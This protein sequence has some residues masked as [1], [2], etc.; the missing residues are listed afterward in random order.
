VL[1]VFSTIQII[2][3]EV[4]TKKGEKK[5]ETLKGSDSPQAT[6]DKIEFN[7][8]AGNPILTITDEGG[9]AGSITLP[10]STPSNTSNKLYNEG[11]II[12]FNGVAIGGNGATEIDDLSDAIYNGNSIFIGELAG[13]NDDGST[14]VGN[15]AFGKQALYNNINGGGNT[16]IGLFSLSNILG[17][18]NTAIGRFSM[19]GS[20][21]IKDASNNT[22]VGSAALRF[23]DSGSENVAIGNSSL[24]SN[25][26]GNKNTVVGTNGLA[27]GTT[28]SNN[29]SIGYS[30]DAYGEGSNNTIIGYEAGY[31]NNPNSKSGSVF[32]GYQAGYFE[33]TDNKLYI[34]NS[35]SATPLIW[36]DFVN[37]DVKINGDFHVTGNITTDG[38]IP[39]VSEINDLSDART[40]GNSIFLGS[41]SG[42]SDDGSDNKN[43]GFGINTLGSNTTGYA[44]TAMGYNSLFFNTEGIQ[45]VGLGQGSLYSNT[46]GG[47][48]VAIGYHSN[49]FNQTGSNNTMIGYQAGR[50]TSA[51]SKSGNVF[52]GYQAGYNEI[53]SNKLYIENSNSASPLIFGDFA[54]NEVKING[55]FEVSGNILN[56]GFLIEDD[57]DALGNEIVLFNASTLN[58]GIGTNL[59]ETVTK[60]HVKGNEG[61]LFQGTHGT[62]TSLNLGTGT[63]FH[64]YT[65]KSAIRGGN[66][67]GTQWDDGNIGDY[68][69]A[70]GNNTIANGLTSTALGAGTQASGSYSAS[71]GVGTKA[72]AFYSTAIGAFNIGGGSPSTIVSTDPVFE[73]G[74]GTDNNNRNNALT[75]LKNGKVG[76]NVSDPLY[77]LTISDNE[78]GVGGNLTRLQL[79]N[80]TATAD[81]SLNG[82]HA[83]LSN[84][85]GDIKFYNLDSESMHITENGSVG[86]GTQTTGVNYLLHVNGS[87][88]KIGGGSWSN[89]S[90]IRLK[91][92]LGIYEKGLT[93][94]NNLRPIKFSYKKNNS[95]GL[96]SDEIEYGF[97]AQ[98]VKKIFP[99]AVSEAQDGYLDFNMHSINV[100]VINAIQELSSR[101]KK[102]EKENLELKDRLDKIERLIEHHQRFISLTD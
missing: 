98:E 65:K 89:S 94:I 101:N 85:Y 8:A 54:T 47:N 50:G 67:N 51:H 35:N 23:V 14:I 93:E 42:I 11:G 90:D 56:N 2:G 100:A 61:V 22:A 25:P 6:G 82:N 75:V 81:L 102:L 92:V 7:N 20:G 84:P 53:G 27:F 26:N 57:W 15:L 59:G 30:A 44:N 60:L 95:R 38:N 86:I 71:L 33:D 13:F 34:E 79:I 9:N 43:Y 62:G 32:I 40:L 83:S 31:Y 3:Q 76:I 97:V 87:A 80:S 5:I 4:D 69:T 12:K 58:L 39:G 72:E 52:I 29:V 66:V 49:H 36:G 46:T 45:N 63:R 21:S 19:S 74:I 24:L 41:G 64:F 77:E 1:I 55:N 99:E 18:N 70:F 96:R 88:G 91:D 17:G 78:D 37:D 10:Q 48:N 68:S 28:G 73:V 16:A